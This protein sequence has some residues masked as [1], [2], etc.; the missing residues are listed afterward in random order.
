METAKAL[1]REEKEEAVTA[2]VVAVK[3]PKLSYIRSCNKHNN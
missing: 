3:E 1:L 2:V